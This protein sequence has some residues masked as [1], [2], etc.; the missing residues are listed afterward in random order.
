MWSLARL[1]DE[2]E[3][4]ARTAPAE[5]LVAWHRELDGPALASRLKALRRIL[6]T[7][8]GEKPAACPRPPPATRSWRYW[9][10]CSPP[11]TAP[12]PGRRNGPIEPNGSNHH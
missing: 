2:W 12:T 9:T 1:D 4:L 5:K 8:N 10:N 11:A 6:D 7:V 3:Q